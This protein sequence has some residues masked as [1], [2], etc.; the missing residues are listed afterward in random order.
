VNAVWKSVHENPLHDRYAQVS[1]LHAGDQFWWVNDIAVVIDA[2]LMPARGFSVELYSLELRVPSRHWVGAVQVRGDVEVRMVGPAERIPVRIPSRR[3]PSL[4]HNISRDLPLGPRDSW[5]ERFHG[6]PPGEILEGEL[7]YPGE[8][9]E[10]GTGLDIGY[11]IKD[12]KSSKEHLQ[13]YVHEFNAG[14]KVFQRASGKRTGKVRKWVNFPREL[15]ILGY[16]IGFSYTDT[17]GRTHEVKGS[18][19]K[20]LAATP[21]NRTLVVVGPKGVEYVLEGGAMRCLDWIYD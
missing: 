3:N 6:T 16:N 8:M 1:Q 12:K 4:H 18:N 17:K 21:S 9:V 2:V 20:Y 11:K 19:K 14:V 13:D 7:W 10:I 5:Y 15:R